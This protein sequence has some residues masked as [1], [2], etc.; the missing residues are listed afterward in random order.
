MNACVRACVWTCVC[1][2][3]SGCSS[4]Y[5]HGAV[6]ECGR[7]DGVDVAMRAP[8]SVAHAPTLTHLRLLKP[9]QGSEHKHACKINTHGRTHTRPCAQ[10]P[11][12]A[13]M[14]R[15]TRR[16]S[17]SLVTLKMAAVVSRSS[18]ALMMRQL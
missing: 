9:N 10:K 14:G 16:D 3:V 8:V 12:H 7:G 1:P 2:F 17:V 13:Y 4:V 6:R 15:S 18:N 11:A 5:V